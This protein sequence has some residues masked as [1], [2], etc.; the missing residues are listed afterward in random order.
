MHSL[1]TAEGASVTQFA[2]QLVTL[3]MSGGFFRGMNQPAAPR[4]A[5]LIA[6]HRQQLA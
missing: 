4:M 1:T 5:Q 2:G 3:Y 6:G